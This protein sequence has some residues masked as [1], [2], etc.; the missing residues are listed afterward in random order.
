MIAGMRVII[1]LL[2]LCAPALADAPKGFAAYPKSRQLCYQHVSGTTMHIMWSTHATAD[3]FD[4]VVAFYE[5]GLGKKA[6]A[7]ANGSKK[8]EVDRDHHVS[9]YAAKNNDAFPSC[10]TKP[11]AGEATIVM[12]STSAR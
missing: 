6:K 7:E 3:A 4:K 9:I 2:A 12:L 11:K 8:I 10:E 1:V 5:K